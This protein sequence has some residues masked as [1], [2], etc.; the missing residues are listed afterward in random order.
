M[1][2]ERSSTHPL[3]DEWIDAFL[4]EHNASVDRKLQGADAASV[5]A[6]AFVEAPRLEPRPP[7]ADAQG[8]PSPRRR[9]LPKPPPQKKT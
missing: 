3:L 6:I 8:Q 1:D 5:P 9:F 2:G 7:T 4:A